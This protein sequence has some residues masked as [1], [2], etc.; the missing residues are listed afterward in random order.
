MIILMN[1]ENDRKGANSEAGISGFAEGSQS[2]RTQN[3]I[4]SMG[5][6]TCEYK[7]IKLYYKVCVVF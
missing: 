3:R 2:I 4:H 6:H 1:F 7:L 5:L